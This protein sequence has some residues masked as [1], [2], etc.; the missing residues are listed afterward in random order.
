MSDDDNKSLL[1]HSW[2]TEQ[3]NSDN[4]SSA[5]LS[6]RFYL[7]IIDTVIM[8][9]IIAGGV[10][11][12][13]LTFVVFWKDNIKTSPS[14]L[15]QSL[16]LIDSTLLLLTIPLFPL[17]SFVVYTHW[18]TAY[19]EILPYVQVYIMPL[20]L[21]AQTASIWV[22]V[23][24][25]VNR[26]IAV[27]F[28]LKSLR[29]CTTSKVKKQL[30]FV[31]LSAVLYNIPRF[32]EY[33]IEYVSYDGKTYTPYVVRTKLR[34]ENLYNIIYDSALYFTFI[35]ALPIFTLTYVNVRLIQVLKARRL[36]RTEMV[37]QRQ[38]N[39]NNV[40]VVLIIVVVVLIICQ[41]PAFVGKALL[42]VTPKNAQWCGGYDFYL[43][44]VA[45]TLVVLNSAVNFVIYVV[46]NNRFRHVLAQTMGCCS[47]LEVDELG[48]RST[49][50]LPLV[51]V[52][53]G[54]N[55]SQENN[56]DRSVEETRL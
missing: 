3:A 48:Q 51:R 5:L 12:N 29:L 32:V 50:T 10:I 18:L 49:R 14:F 35:V 38:Q 2:M 44:P 47:V 22:V 25:A 56:N 9:T 6:C 43:R 21:I 13:S 24:F 1:Q 42:N 16:A 55:I 36:K 45:N 8:G 39:D 31:L 52:V 30:A 26:Y 46:F 28:P 23:L 53:S 54:I 17:H 15:F 7:F 11:G 40:T 34:T 41:V 19:L 20:A 27:W 4:V 37:N 33:R